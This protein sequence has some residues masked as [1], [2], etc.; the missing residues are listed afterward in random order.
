MLKDLTSYAEKCSENN[1]IP[2]QIFQSTIDS[3]KVCMNLVEA[4]KHDH[5]IEK[6]AFSNIHQNMSSTIEKVLINDQKLV[7]LSN[8]PMNA[9]YEQDNVDEKEM[10][11]LWQMHR[12]MAKEWSYMNFEGIIHDLEVMVNCLYRTSSCS[13]SYTQLVL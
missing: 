1:I 11:C 2:M 12:S 3:I 9:E 4:I 5:E 7:G 10:S 6:N 13:N 8:D